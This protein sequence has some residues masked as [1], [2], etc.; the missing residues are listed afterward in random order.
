MRRQ[1]YFKD[2]CKSCVYNLYGI[3]PCQ[4]MNEPQVIEFLE[5]ET[6]EKDCCPEWYDEW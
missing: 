6:E 1:L 2:C 5:K 3:P 4:K